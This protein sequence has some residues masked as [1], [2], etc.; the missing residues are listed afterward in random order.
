MLSVQELKQFFVLL[1]SF[2]ANHNGE[3]LDGYFSVKEL[4]KIT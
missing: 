3:N 1:N 2:S 4:V